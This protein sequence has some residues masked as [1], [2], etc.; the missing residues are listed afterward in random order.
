MRMQGELDFETAVLPER[1]FLGWDAPLVTKVIDY[2]WQRRAHLP[3]MM[4]V[5]P[6]AQSGRR[7]REMLAERGGCLAPQVV[8]PTFF[9]REGAGAGGALAE[10]I[11]W[12]QTLKAV[13]WSHYEEIIPVGAAS[14]DEGA[15]G[16]IQQI[17]SIRAEL[18]ESGHDLFIAASRLP[19]DHAEKS[20]WEALSKL[21]KEYRFSM[22]KL[23]YSDP[24][25]GKRKAAAEFKIPDG[26]TQLVLAGV[27]DPVPLAQ[28][29]WQ[30]WASDISI[31]VLIHAPS[32]ESHAFNEWGQPLTA[33]WTDR[34]LEVGSNENITL[35]ETPADQAKAAVRAIS[36]TLSEKESIGRNDLALGVCDSAI[37]PEV[38]RVFAERGWTIFDPGGK[39]LGQT[40]FLSW[41]EELCRWLDRGDVR[42]LSNLLPQVWT[43]RLLERKTYY[44]SLTLAEIVEVALPQT[45]SDLAALKDASWLVGHRREGEIRKGAE[46]LIGVCKQLNYYKNRFSYDGVAETLR[47]MVSKVLADEPETVAA[48][49]PLLDEVERLEASVKL[50]AARWISLLGRAL[51]SLRVESETVEKSLDAQGWLE[52]G[53][54]PA[55]TLVL[56]GFNDGVVPENSLGDAWLPDAMRTVLGLKDNRSR[57]ARDA[58]YTVSLVEA[59][60]Q[61]GGVQFVVGRW[62][63]GGESL[64]PSRLLLMPPRDE[65]AA[66]VKHAFSAPDVMRPV[67][68]WQRDWL[69]NVPV[70]AT[71]LRLSPTALSL[72]L[73]CPFRYYLKHV[74]GM[75]RPEILREEWSQRE[76]GTI[77]HEVLERFGRDSQAR[78]FTKSDPITAWLS[79]E[80]DKVVAE[81]FTE[82]PPLAVELQVESMRQRLSFFAKAQ[83]E[84]RTAGWEIKYV[85]ERMSMTFCDVE[86]NGIIDRIDYNE[87]L[88]QWMVWDYK[89]GK[90]ALDPKKA[91]CLPNDKRSPCPEHLEG[92]EEFQL[93]AL[94]ASNR[95]KESAHTWTNL[96]L[97]LYAAWLQ[98]E[99]GVQ[100]GVG[101]ISMMATR[102]EVGFR[103]WVNYREDYSDGAL[104]AAGKV[105]ELLK[106]NTFWPPAK[107]IKYD[108]YEELVDDDSLKDAVLWSV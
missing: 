102:H 103:P 77:I 35:C 65:L 20:R 72:Y 17:Q 52:L 10:L 73:K 14:G 50:P 27:P 93:M 11:A 54:E 22:R 88:D 53:Y 29:V 4:V 48:T 108:D 105:A 87:T 33:V 55:P 92:A 86:L 82:T 3:T 18:A 2:L 94:A 64:M 90:D 12:E 71:K 13:D 36:D 100:A 58:F 8:T 56:C 106:E 37:L 96:Q 25:D 79:S 21:E 66:R 34:T 95:V 60:R 75:Q 99:K 39:T 63:S 83:A 31:E 68:A 84:Q 38:T 51:G 81:R 57:F 97:P 6:T 62:A 67:L 40:G 26:V 101:Y 24:Q 16:L 49:A 19:A 43:E 104:A 30:R 1:V 42:T 47:E 80:L 44:F 7:L 45:T 91:H 89:T 69:L 28:T 23:G 76:F 5:V 85:E 70:K 98:K 32:D 78:D 107:K 15:R 61:E 59:R 41:L 46:D 9:F 74:L